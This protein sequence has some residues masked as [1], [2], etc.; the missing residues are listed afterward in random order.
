ME[1]LSG[2]VGKTRGSKQTVS[3]VGSE[4]PAYVVHVPCQDPPRRSVRTGL[5]LTALEGVLGYFL[6]AGTTLDGGRSAGGGIGE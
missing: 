5:L 3:P 1:K 4:K 6:S 2:L